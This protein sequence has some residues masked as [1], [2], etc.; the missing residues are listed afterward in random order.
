MVGLEKKDEVSTSGDVCSVHK[1]VA[2]TTVELLGSGSSGYQQSTR[3]L[4]TLFKLINTVTLGM[5]ADL[6]VPCDRARFDDLGLDARAQWVGKGKQ[7]SVE[8]SR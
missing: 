4:R 5:T 7:I 2:D 8:C 6:R 1:R 3:E